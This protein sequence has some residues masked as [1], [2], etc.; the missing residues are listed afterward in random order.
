MAIT[1][2]FNG[3]YDVLLI[4]EA[5]T[6]MLYSKL[7]LHK[8]RRDDEHNERYSTYQYLEERLDKINWSIKRP[9]YNQLV[10]EYPTLKDLE[11]SNNP[12]ILRNISSIKQK[13]L[14]YKD[15]WELDDL[16][17]HLH[18]KVCKQII[19]SRMAYSWGL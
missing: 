16:E 7:L 6:M 9:Y 5:N 10:A 18:Q 14:E 19:D 12:E 11:L 17:K 1:R 13:Q 8:N 15:I 3:L 4:L 2:L